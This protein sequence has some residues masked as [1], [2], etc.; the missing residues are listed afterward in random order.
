M[1]GPSIIFFH[2]WLLRGSTSSLN[3]PSIF[4]I[5]LHFSP[6]PVGQNSKQGFYL[7]F[8]S[9][10]HIFKIP[11]KDSIID[12][13]LLSLQQMRIVYCRFQQVQLETSLFSSDLSRNGKELLPFTGNRNYQSHFHNIC[14]HES[15]VSWEST[16]SNEYLYSC[17]NLT[18]FDRASLKSSNYYWPEPEPVSSP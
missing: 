1:A 3:L 9:H 5:I 2:I 13:F 7:S 8:Y 17:S 14:F 16:A 15:L 18:H 12:W 11:W 6:T 4:T 10:P